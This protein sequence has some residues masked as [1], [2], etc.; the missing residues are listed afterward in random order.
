MKRIIRNIG[1]AAL[2]WMALPFTACSEEDTNPVV[3][4]RYDV[5]DEYQLPHTNPETITFRV[6]SLYTPWEVIGAEDGDWYTISPSHG[7]A[8]ETAM[9]TVTVKDNTSLDDR[10]DTIIIKSDYW[11]GK[12]FRLFQKGTAYL[13]AENVVFEQNGAKH[14][15]PVS[16]NQKW[17]AE[18]TE[19]QNWLKITSGAT[20]ERDG[21]IGVETS[22]NK[23][24]QR[25]GK[26]MIYDRYDRPT[27]EVLVTQEGYVLNP[28]YPEDPDPN[29]ET[30]SWIRLYDEEQTLELPIESNGTWKVT[31][32]NAEFAD[33]FDVL[34]TQ[35][36]GDGV[37]RIHLTANTTP[38]VRTGEVFMEIVSDDPDALPVE[39]TIKFK[40]GNARTGELM[41][42]NVSVS[43]TRNLG[44]SMGCG[45][46]DFYV[47]GAANADLRLT[48]YFPNKPWTDGNAR[49]LRYWTNRANGTDDG[50]PMISTMPWVGGA[51]N[52]DQCVSY[53]KNATPGTY[54]HFDKNQPHVLS[55]EISK[56]KLAGYDDLC[57]YVTWYIDGEVL[58]LGNGTNPGIMPS[59]ADGTILASNNWD[60]TYEEMNDTESAYISA[61]GNFTITK[62]TFAAPIDWG[63]ND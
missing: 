49:E 28:I 32:L 52:L 35:G 26:I 38:A 55:L 33:W 4:L 40:Q 31:K 45:R 48:F 54:A 61:I 27:V 22:T 8:G 18:V 62:W 12:K 14:Q 42:E 23:G 21:V 57:A 43:G 16:T 47:Q 7:E 37:L 3:D 34:T 58:A 50:I 29:E 46:Y 5:E 41:G 6:R 1:I 39:K 53:S 10:E 30:V 44:T 24:E 51:F 63:G 15:I 59:K 60:M 13:T 36:T 2:A 9:V 25:P 17:S 56:A 20:G 19:G 11:T